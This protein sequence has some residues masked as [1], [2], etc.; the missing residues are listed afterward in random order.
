MKCNLS[1]VWQ[2]TTEDLRVARQRE[3]TEAE[4][5]AFYEAQ[6][7][8]IRSLKTDGWVFSSEDGYHP[9]NGDTW[10]TNYFKSP[11]MIAKA[12]YNDQ[13]DLIRREAF[14]YAKEVYNRRATEYTQRIT[15]IIW[16]H[17]E[18]NP[19]AIDAPEIGIVRIQYAVPSHQ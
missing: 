14:C 5:Q 4:K 8:L 2:R 6:Q 11:R 16:K 9:H 19:N 18:E 15:D 7:K 3:K 17:F 1:K 13:H 12:V 10:S